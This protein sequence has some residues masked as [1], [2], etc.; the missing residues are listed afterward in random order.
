M[1]VH[2]S[3]AKIDR[4]EQ[5]AG[6][7]SECCDDILT[8]TSPGRVVECAKLADVER[9]VAAFV[10]E[11]TAAGDC[12]RIF[13][14]DRSPRGVRACPGFKKLPSSN[15]GI[16]VNEAVGLA[17][18]LGAEFL[19]GL[20]EWRAGKGAIVTD[21]HPTKAAAAEAFLTTAGKAVA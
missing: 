16:L 18:G 5:S 2:L 14:F 3:F 13:T 11:M 21:W 7:R 20:D 17:L 6:W 1:R 15:G 9:E 4:I 8:R 10:A 19:T 12:G